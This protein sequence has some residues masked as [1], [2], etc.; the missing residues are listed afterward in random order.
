[1]ELTIVS[2]YWRSSPSSILTPIT[3]SWGGAD[4]TS[5][6]PLNFMHLLSS[7]ISKILWRGI[8]AATVIIEKWIN[9]RVD[10]WVT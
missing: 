5:M 1:M 9:D 3:Y 4:G 6:S 10:G 8:D 7:L 2:C